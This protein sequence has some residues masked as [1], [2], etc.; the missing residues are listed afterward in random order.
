LT[1]AAIAGKEPSRMAQSLRF[2]EL[3][4]GCPGAARITDFLLA[5][6]GFYEIA[7][8]F[9][10]RAPKIDLKSKRILARRAIEYPLQRRF[11]QGHRPSIA[12]SNSELQLRKS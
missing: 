8:D 6:F 1:G 9:T 10:P 7:W 2:F 11:G 4:R 5:R 3:I 12:H